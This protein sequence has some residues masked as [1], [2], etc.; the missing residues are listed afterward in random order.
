[1]NVNTRTKY[2]LGNIETEWVYSRRGLRQGYILSP[3]LFSLHTKK[4]IP[5]VKRT[6]GMKVGNERLVILMYA[7]DLI[8]MCE[9][10]EDLQEVLNAV[11]QYG[12]FSVKFSAEKSK[13]LVING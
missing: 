13:V 12:S 1:M 3:F 9:S 4:L 7:D 2:A 6:L 8:I 10:A 5:R 11:T